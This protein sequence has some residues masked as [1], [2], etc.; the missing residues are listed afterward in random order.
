M[1]D[2]EYSDGKLPHGGDWA[3]YKEEYGRLPLDFSASISPLGLPEGVQRA[4]VRA[5][6]EADRYPDPLC[7]SLRQKLSIFHGVEPGRIVCGNGAADL[8]TRIAWALRP[9]R[10]LIAVPGF[11]EYRRSLD[12][13]LCR[14]ERFVLKEED[15]FALG[16]EIAARITPEIDLLFLA[17]PMN[18]SGKRIPD[19]LLMRILDAC[20]R[21][22]TV[23]VLDECFLPMTPG[24]EA[25][26]LIG[27]PLKRQG[28]II[29]RAFTK[30]YAMAGLR[31][32]YALCA[33]DEMAGR[34]SFCGQPWSVS[35]VSQAAGEAALLEKD[36]EERLM[37]LLAAERPRLA[38]ELEDLGFTVIPGEAPYILFKSP[39]KHLGEKLRDEGIL[40]R[41]CENFE[42]LCE[43]WYRT[44]V[45]TREDNDRLLE[46]MRA[47]RDGGM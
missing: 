43:G 35:A 11:S 36:Y 32:G 31:L 7:R 33:D 46:A 16:E 45:R 22:G 12:A 13:V 10:A 2:K 44:A 8:I 5:L 6:A 24:G 40:I 42:G 21:T 18:P 25:H 19:D 37:R 20:D 23:F 38:G 26:T 30:T 9:R 28:F 4:A 39:V 17:N 41:S 47:V 15:G 3:S 14:T 29:L 1:A 34:L 27:E